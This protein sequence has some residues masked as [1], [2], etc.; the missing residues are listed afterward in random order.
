[1][2]NE[3]VN[4]IIERKDIDTLRKYQLVELEILLVIDKICR[5]NNLKYWIDAGTLL[6]AVRHKGFIPWDD[7]CDICM[8]RD[9]YQKLNDIIEKSLPSDLQ[10][11]SRYTKNW[12]QKHKTEK[13]GFMQIYYTKNFKG[14]D[15]QVNKEHIGAYIDIF[16]VDSIEEGMCDKF[17][18]KTI[19]KIIHM[20]RKEKDTIK[21]YTKHFLQKIPLENIWINK[22]KKLDNDNK[23]KYLVYGV[24]TVFMESKYMQRKEDIYPLIELE[25]E[26]KNLYAPSNYENYLRTLYGDYMKLPCENNRTGHL[27]NLEI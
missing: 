4:K 15:I 19:N 1:M 8:P 9:D 5:D 12:V 2:F 17:R 6:G 26:G 21:D 16:P 11:G 23:S 10:F 3:K 22:C 18:Y 13:H 20:E 14:F 7:D 25:F 27:I 24:E